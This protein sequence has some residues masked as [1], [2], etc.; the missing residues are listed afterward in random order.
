MEIVECPGCFTDLNIPS[1]EQMDEL[2]T[3]L[4]DMPGY[5]GLTL[6]C[7][8]CGTVFP[9][10]QGRTPAQQEQEAK[11]IIARLIREMREGR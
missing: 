2:R 6:C 7:K 10:S 8:F 3:A 4:S 9:A 1:L 5:E 11:D